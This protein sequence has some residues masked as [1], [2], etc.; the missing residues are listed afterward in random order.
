MSR[1]SNDLCEKL[2]ISLPH[3]LLRQM[4]KF[5]KNSGESRSSFIQRAIRSFMESQTRRKKIEQYIVGYSKNPETADE[6]KAAEEAATYLLA[7]E[8]WE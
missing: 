3:A 2:A 7:E 1:S 4:E 6:I 5:R 8:S